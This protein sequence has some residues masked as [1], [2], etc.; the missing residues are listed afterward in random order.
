MT[1]RWKHG[2]LTQQIIGAFYEVYNALGYGFL[3]KVYENALVHQLEKIGLQVAQQVPLDVYFD[4]VIVGQYFADLMVNDQ[5][6][7]ELKAV[8][9]IDEVHAAQLRNYLRATNCEVGLVLNFGP[10]PTFRRQVMDNHHKPHGDPKN[11]E[12]E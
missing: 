10:K 12:H 5:I 1:D 6:V 4:G 7:V 11:I 3:E 9:A 8:D 2:E